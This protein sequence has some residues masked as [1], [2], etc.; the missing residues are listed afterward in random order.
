M[1]LSREQKWK[2]RDRLGGVKVGQVEI[3]AIWPRV[4]VVEMDRFRT[5]FSG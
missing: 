3:M 4:A 1:E 5:H 2:W